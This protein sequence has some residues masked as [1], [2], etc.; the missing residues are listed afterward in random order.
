[1]F[2]DSEDISFEWTMRLLE[3]EVEGDAPSDGRGTWRTSGE[4]IC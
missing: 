4:D 1:M 2:I 3:V